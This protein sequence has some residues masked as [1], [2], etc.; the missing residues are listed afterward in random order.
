MN[1]LPLIIPSFALLAAMAATAVGDELPREANISRASYYGLSYAE[2]P[3][4]VYVGDKIEAFQTVASTDQQ[5]AYAEGEDVDLKQEQTE[6][7]CPTGCEVGCPIY[8][9]PACLTVRTEYLMWWTRRRNLPPLVT[10]SPD[11]TARGQAGIF[12]LDDTEVLFGDETV[13]QNLRSGGRVTISQLLDPYGDWFADFRVWGVEDSA[14]SFSVESDGSPIIGIPF[15]NA[16]IDD[17]DAL[18][19]AFPG[20]STNGRVQ[21]NIHNDLF[22]ADASARVFWNHGCHWETYLLGGYQFTRMDDSLALNSQTTSIDPGSAI[23]VGTQI[24]IQDIFRTQNEFH[25]GQLGFLA[26][27]QTDRWSLEVLGKV[28]LGNMHQSVDIRGRTL[29]SNVD[30]PSE[31]G[32][33]ARSSNIGFYTRDRLAF[34]PELNVTSRYHLNDCWS[35]TLGYSFLYLNDV[36]LAAN[37][38]DR[39]VNF[40]ARDDDGPPRFQF[41]RTD[42]WAQG[43]SFGVEYLW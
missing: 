19:I 25:G 1:R 22:G 9:N 15:T 14:E 36:L 28:A 17:E 23:P 24:D 39:R 32:L 5:T 2:K 3:A 38:I 40:V 8:C 26:N 43:L 34:I 41:N 13:G 16:T 20:V 4:P 10:T 30:G 21:A 31:G 29:A 6:Q 18:L 42:Y 7:C 12:G 35:L 11:G 37:Q 27:Y 33:L